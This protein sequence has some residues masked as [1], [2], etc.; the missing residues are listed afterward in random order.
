VFSH[1]TFESSGV[2]V[3]KALLFFC[4]IGWI[5][6]FKPFL[7]TM[8][9]EYQEYHQQLST[10]FHSHEET[11]RTEM[12]MIEA[13]FKSSLDC[14][15][16]VCK[17]VKAAGFRDTREEICFFREVKPS[18]AAFIE[19]Y[20]FRYHAILFAPVNDTLEMKRFW[21]WEEKKMQRFYDD[22]REFCRYMREGDTHRDT[23]Y[24]LRAAVL[25]GSTHT[26]ELIHDLDA[27]LVSPKDPLVTI[28]KAYELYEQYIKQKLVNYF[29]A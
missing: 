11:S 24:F 27:G 7:R 28:M 9:P 20:T 25:S 14:W 6:Y 15:G 29:E 16:K 22:N 19:Y 8:S 5:G 13:C 23:E 3:Y 4:R 26:T 10:A 2:C 18:F 21:R 1:V 17:E 12:E